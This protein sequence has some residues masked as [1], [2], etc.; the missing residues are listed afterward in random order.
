M[1][2]LAGM[3]AAILYAF[4]DKS[5]HYKR[6]LLASITIVT[7]TLSYFQLTSPLP[8]PFTKEDAVALATSE[9]G[10]VIDNFPKTIG[11]WE[12]KVDGYE[13]RRETSVATIDHEIYIVTF[14][15]TWSEAATWKLSYKVERGSSSA[16]SESGVMPPYYKSRTP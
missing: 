8:P 1:L 2:A 4:V 16:Y 5:Q 10:T 15:E 9:Q 3:A 13:V 14:T 6:W 11:M 7:V 12:G